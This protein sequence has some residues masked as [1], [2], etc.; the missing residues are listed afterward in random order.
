LL[1]GEQSGVLA[2]ADAALL[3]AA[4]GEQQHADAEDDQRPDDDTRLG[5]GRQRL[6]VVADAR[7]LLDFFQDARC[8]P[9]MVS[10]AG[11]R[12]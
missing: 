1:V 3:D 12:R 7:G 10:N 4:E 6:P 11:E 9:A 2:L 5:A 8:A